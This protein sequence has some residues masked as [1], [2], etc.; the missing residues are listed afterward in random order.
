MPLTITTQPDTSIKPA[1]KEGIAEE[2]VGQELFL[3]DDHNGQ[4]VHC[5]NS[6][7]A[8]IWFLCDGTRTLAH[9][10]RELA[11]AYGLPEQQVWLEVQETVAQFQK[12]GLLKA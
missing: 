10:T 12:L 2:M 9:I 8:L 4:S 7:A 6:G 1:P 5:L 3:Y 11:T